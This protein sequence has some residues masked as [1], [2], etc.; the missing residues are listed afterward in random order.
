MICQ[1]LAAATVITTPSEPT[2]GQTIPVAG[3]SGGYDL[4]R[5]RLAFA[6]ARLTNG[7]STAA[8]PQPRM[9]AAAEICTAVIFSAA[10]RWY[11]AAVHVPWAIM[12]ARRMTVSQDAIVSRVM[13][14]G[15]T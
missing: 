13:V 12:A 7:A 14:S 11:S 9:T 1:G 8:W 5:S 6:L 15:R 2:S 4:R 10:I 3:Y